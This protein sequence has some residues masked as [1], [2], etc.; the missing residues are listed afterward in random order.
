ME[1]GNEMI[2]STAISVRLREMAR[3]EEMAVARRRRA[4]GKEGRRGGGV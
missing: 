3:Y 1:E 4:D 2:E